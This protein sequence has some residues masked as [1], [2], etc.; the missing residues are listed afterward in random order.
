MADPFTSLSRWCSNCGGFRRIYIPFDERG[1]ANREIA[2]LHITS[3]GVRIALVEVPSLRQCRCC[4][5]RGIDSEHDNWT[6][7]HCVPFS[8]C[9]PAA[10][11]LS[12]SREGDPVRYS[13]DFR[14]EARREAWQIKLALSQPGWEVSARHARHW[15]TTICA[16]LV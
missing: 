15:F 7:A 4:G 14:G 6:A 10:S 13:C 3:F 1:P 2:S 16:G 8:R 5:S 12:L 9:S 11:G